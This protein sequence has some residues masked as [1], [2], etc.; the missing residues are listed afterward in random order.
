LPSVVDVLK[1]LKPLKTTE[2]SYVFLNQEGRPLN[3]HTWR[4][5]VWY[6]ILKGL[7]I[8]P[9]K[10]YCTRHTFISIGLS[11]GVNIKWLAEYC[12]TSVTM[13][14]RHYGRYVR[15]DAAEQLSKLAGTVTQT[16]TQPE[17]RQA[18]AGEVAEKKRGKG[19]WAHLDSNQGPTGYEPVALTN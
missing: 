9:H 14:E 11:N 1:P 10:P 2:R 7:E 4:G 8:R 6:G 12:G 3:F 5:G 13:I 15:S 19:W 18:V 16:V 17:K